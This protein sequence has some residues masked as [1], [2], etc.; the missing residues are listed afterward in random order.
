M[1]IAN[2]IAS[3]AGFASPVVTGYLTDGQVKQ[4]WSMIFL[5]KIVKYPQ[6]QQTI[7]A[8]QKV[9][10]LAALF[11]GTGGLLFIL[12]C[13]AE[14]QYYNDPEWREKKKLEVE[15]RGETIHEMSDVEIPQID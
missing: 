14:V 7:A 15:N 11:Q 12:L 6:F 8:W 10:V 13:T 1:G 5:N 4:G 3:C 9:F 2:T